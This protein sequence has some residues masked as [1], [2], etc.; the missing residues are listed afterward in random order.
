ME[1]ETFGPC[2]NGANSNAWI[3][4]LGGLSLL[5]TRGEFQPP[6]YLNM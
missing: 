3:P 1:N 4:H 2:F 5:E 6:G